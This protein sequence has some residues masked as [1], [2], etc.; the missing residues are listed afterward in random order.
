M[1]TITATLA[2]RLDRELAGRQALVP[3]LGGA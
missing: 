2:D 3:V 1:T